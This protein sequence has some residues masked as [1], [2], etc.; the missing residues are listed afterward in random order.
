[1]LKEYLN[2]L[3]KDITKRRTK[4][5]GACLASVA[6]RRAATSKHSGS[7]RPPYSCRAARGFNNEMVRTHQARPDRFFGIRK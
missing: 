3:G 1:M 6:I 4:I 2:R 5:F 7:H